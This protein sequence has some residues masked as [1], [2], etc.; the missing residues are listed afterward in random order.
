M[1]RLGQT[2]FSQHLALLLQL[3][4]VAADLVGLGLQARACRA[5]PA[6]ALVPYQALVVQGHLVKDLLVVHLRQEAPD[7]RLAV[8]DQA[9]LE[10][11]PML[12]TAHH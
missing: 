5:G 3:A 2:P 4:A 8:G 7:M 6:A 12:E 10:Q 11:A 9:R 1:G